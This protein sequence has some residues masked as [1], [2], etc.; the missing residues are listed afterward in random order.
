MKLRSGKVTNKLYTCKT[1][2][3]AMQESLR[4]LHVVDAMSIDQRI[5]YCAKMYAI[6]FNNLNI[7]KFNQVK[8]TIIIGCANRHICEIRENIS[9]IKA[10]DAIDTIQL[11]EDVICEL[12]KKI[13]KTN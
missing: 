7:I 4:Q 13:N 2:R 5:E 6:L 3:E 8:L 10:V 9:L 12:S 11:L 1:Q